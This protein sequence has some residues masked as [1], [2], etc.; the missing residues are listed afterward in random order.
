MPGD[1]AFRPNRFV[2]ISASMDRKVMAIEVYEPEMRPFPHARSIAAVGA[3][4]RFRGASVG[5]AAAEALVVI[6]EVVR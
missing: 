3:L 2:D 4:A 5:L 1:P 6:R